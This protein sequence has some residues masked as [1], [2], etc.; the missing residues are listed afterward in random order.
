MR[1]SPTALTTYIFFLKHHWYYYFFSPGKIHK[2]KEGQSERQNSKVKYSVCL[3]ATFKCYFQISFLLDFGGGGARIGRGWVGSGWVADGE[4]GGGDEPG[5][6][7]FP[8]FFVVVVVSF[9]DVH[10]EWCEQPEGKKTINLINKSQ[11]EEKKKTT[12][13]N[14]TVEILIL[15]KKNTQQK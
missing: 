11:H 8:F 4:G 5:Q 3:V 7:G 9:A 1:Y 2:Q 14:A 6:H 15:E 13:Q 10:V 12:Q